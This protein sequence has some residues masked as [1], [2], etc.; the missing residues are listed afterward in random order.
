M[1]DEETT[2][3]KIDQ[4]NWTVR[5]LVD[6]KTVININPLWQRGPA[7]KPQRQALLVD[8]ILRGM[9]IPK[10][11]VRKL[12]GKVFSHEV[13]DGQQRIRA[14]WEFRAGQIP[15]KHPDKIAEIDGIVVDGLRY[16]ALPKALRDRFDEFTLSIGEITDASSDEITNLFGRLQMGVSLNPAELR[17]A[18]LKPLGLVIDTMATSHAFFDDCR[19]ADTRYKRQDYVTHLFT[20]AA[21]NGSRNIKAPDLRAMLAEYTPD[22]TDE[23]LELTA[24]VGEALSTLDLVNQQLGYKIVQKWIFVDL[25]WLILQWQ[26]EG[27][28]V[29]PIKLAESYKKFDALRREHT[30]DP[31]ALLRAGHKL[32]DRQASNLYAYINAFRTQGGEHGNLGI[33]NLALRAFTRQ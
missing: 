7:W 11:Y 8:S 25:G 3:V 1:K 30:S 15:L 28:E 6:N 27:R 14:I 26:E 17:N 9:D 5:K 32:S 24:R 21:Y 16:S 19:I 22:R 29:D 33:R 12:T 4:R 10:I 20:M 31:A 13:V 23:I 2:N 18:M